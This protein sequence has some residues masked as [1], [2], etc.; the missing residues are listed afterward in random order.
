MPRVLSV[1][2]ADAFRQRLVEAAEALIV[3]RRSADFSMRELAQALGCSPMLPYRYFRDKDDILA[4]V[5]ASAFTRF[6][7]ALEAPRAPP[8]APTQRSHG[9]GDAYVAFAF[10]NPVLYRFIFDSAPVQPGR[11]PDLDRAG[12]RARETMTSHVRDLVSQGILAGDPVDIG[13]L[14]WAGLHG[15]IMLQ[16][17]GQLA[18]EP[19]FEHL[20]A[21]LTQALVFGLRAQPA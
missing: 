10:A 7:Q 20:R 5:R 17:A 8:D 9:V 3:G 14:F 2:E 16:L 18:P 6:A 12:L 21:A 1:G 13:H 15:L 4:A 19:G 11:Y